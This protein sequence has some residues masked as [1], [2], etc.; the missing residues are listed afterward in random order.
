[1]IWGVVVTTM[2]FVADVE[3]KLL[4]AVSFTLYV[5]TLGNTRSGDCLSDAA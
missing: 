2:S 3:P 1:M 4:L 5:P